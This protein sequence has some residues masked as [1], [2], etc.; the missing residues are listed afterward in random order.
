MV[1]GR[2]IF[3]SRGSEDGELYMKGRVSEVKI[4]R[5]RLDDGR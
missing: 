2:V 4:K 1:K 3:N 5:W